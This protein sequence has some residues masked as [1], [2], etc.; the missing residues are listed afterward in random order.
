MFN[1]LFCCFFFGRK[2][3]E[4]TKRKIKEMKHKW[5]PEHILLK[6]YQKTTKNLRKWN[7]STMGIDIFFKYIPWTKF[8]DRLALNMFRVLFSIGE[9]FPFL[10][11][12]N[13]KIKK[14]YLNERIW[15]RISLYNYHKMINILNILN[16]CVHSLWGCS[17]TTVIKYIHTFVWCLMEWIAIALRHTKNKSN[18][19][20]KWLKL[21]TFFH[22]N[23][24]IKFLKSK[25]NKCNSS[26]QK[27][28]RNQNFDKRNKSIVY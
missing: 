26:K 8:R 6:I 14:N 9:K 19:S 12:L 22:L 28:V 27:S 13:Q 11:Y 16:C 2:K 21:L 5:S 23:Q 10:I 15:N 24:S 20:S 4:K 1:Y 25:P 7:Q 17:I 18:H 3:N